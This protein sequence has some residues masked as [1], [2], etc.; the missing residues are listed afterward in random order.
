MD[1]VTLSRIQFA[2]N[3]GFHYLFPPMSI[4]LGLLIVVMEGFYMKTKDVF[5]KNLTQFWIKIFSLFFAM[6]VATGFVQVFSFGNN[7]AYFSR[8]VGDVFGTLL[9]AEGIFAFFLE[10]GFLGLMLFGWDKIKPRTHYLSTIL[11]VFG[12]HFSAIWITFA[13]SWMQTPAGFKVIGEGA[14]ARAVVTNIWE[15]YNNPSAIERLTHTIFGCWINGAFLMISVGAYYLLK[16]RYQPFGKFSL[17]LGL[18]VGL[19]VLIL[20]ALSGDDTAKGVAARQPIKLAA[21]EGI[22]ETKEHTPI[23]VMGYVDK[24]KQQTVGIKIPGFLSFLVYGNFKKAVPGLNEFPK[25]NWPNVPA[26]FQFYHIMIICWGL[27]FSIVL[28]G[29]IGMRKKR[30]ENHPK[31]LWILIFSIILPYI[32]NTAGWF[33]AEMGR[34]PWLVYNVLKTHEGIS[35]SIHEGQVFGSLVMFIFI[36]ALLFSMFIFML[37]RKIQ[38]GPEE[39]DPDLIY[40]DQKYFTSSKG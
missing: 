8:F 19:V 16:K 22:Y 32:A 2:L 25:E 14:Q 33:T 18:I 34:Q 24:E 28:L 10:A 15:V 7:W 36:Y 4:G 39:I 30:I 26:V 11:V 40:K 23:T 37:N 35:R 31:L 17:K 29:F 5:Y 9:A 38:H 13:N 3:I 12:A 6:G 27:M 21:M 1:V 20:Q